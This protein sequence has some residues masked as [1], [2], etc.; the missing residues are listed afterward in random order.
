[1]SERECLQCG[2][3]QEAIRA[4]Q[5]RGDPIYCATGDAYEAD[6][7]WDRHRFRDLTDKELSG[8]VLPE[9]FD[10]YRRIVSLWEV[11]NEHKIP[12]RRDRDDY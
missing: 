11:A 4:S 2:E 3:R 7:E 6:Y 8:L 1:M 9:F 10:L 5:R 12:A